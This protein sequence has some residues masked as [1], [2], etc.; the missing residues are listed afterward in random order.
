[1]VNAEA[2]ARPALRIAFFGTPVFAV[3]SLE[4]LLRSRHTIAGVVTQPD[5][6][7]GRGQRQS[8][9]PVKQVAL[10]N[11]FPLLQ[12]ERIR[13]PGIIDILRTWNIDLGVV[14]AYG[15]ILPSGLL[16]LPPLGMI[17]VHASLLPKYRG[18]API[19]RAVMAGET[20]TGITIIRLIEELDAGPMLGMATRSIGSNETSEVLEQDLAFLGAALLMSVIDDMA[21]GMAHEVNQDPASASYAPRLTKAE[22]LIDW[23]RSAR[24]IHNQIRGLYPWPHAFTYLDGVRFIILESLVVPLSPTSSDGAAHAGHILK[25]SGDD[26]TVSAGTDSIAIRRI[27]PEGRRP[28]SVREF[29]SG[30]TLHP[31]Q[32]FGGPPGS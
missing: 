22:G 1:V 3:P 2:G 23:A 20:E 27:Q 5:R 9:S 17:N 19:Q 24:D 31:G 26:L 8:D 14:A 12:P 29:L 11:S 7:R 21:T 32:T 10:E 4:H 30:H 16:Q 15:K 18:A 6:P 13:D 28:L 25:A